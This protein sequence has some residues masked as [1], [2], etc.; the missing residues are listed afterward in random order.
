MQQQN[1]KMDHIAPNADD[2][3]GNR[4]RPENKKHSPWEILTHPSTKHQDAFSIF[5]R[6]F[7][8]IVC[9]VFSIHLKEGQ[10]FYNHRPLYNMGLV[11]I[12]A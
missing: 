6:A 3:I 8:S 2:N 1:M 4:V 7:S 11:G 10:H 5:D 9:I 12:S